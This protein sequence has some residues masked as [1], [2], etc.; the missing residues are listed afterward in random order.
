MENQ[1]KDQDKHLLSG[2]RQVA[3]NFKDI[4]FYHLERYIKATNYILPSDTVLD[5]GCG[6]G[7]GTAI[8]S[9]YSKRIVGVDDS[10]E[11]IQYANKY[12]KKNNN[13]FFHEDIFK[14][15]TYYDVIV[16]FEIIEH[17][18]NT[19]ELFIFL[20]ERALKYFIFSVPSKE[21][22]V[23]RSKWHWK[24]FEYNEIKKYL[25][26]IGFNIQVFQNINKT[27]F[28]VARRRT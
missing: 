5:L 15:D 27:L 6:C 21:I 18:K 11:A 3:N 24:H 16:A 10:L 13:E 1:R 8:L 22:P 12:W 25:D 4:D 20:G 7:Y 23:K 28:F 19:E 17:I 26:K 14:I 2:E 9:R